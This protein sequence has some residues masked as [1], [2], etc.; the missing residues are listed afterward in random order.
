MVSRA[1]VRVLRGRFKKK[2]KKKKKKGGVV[3]PLK[4]TL[5]VAVPS[6]FRRANHVE[7]DGGRGDD[8]A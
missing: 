1:V 5:P 4:P 2:K 8:R 6:V 3:E 7:A